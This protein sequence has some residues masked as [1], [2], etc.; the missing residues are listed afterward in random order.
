MSLELPSFLGKAVTEGKKSRP[1]EVGARILPI[2][3]GRGRTWET[4]SGYAYCLPAVARSR[5]EAHFAR[6]AYA[7]APP[8]LQA[9]GTLAAHAL[10]TAFLHESAGCCA[11]WEK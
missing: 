8:L 9:C 10:E 3:D 6:N 2:S 11:L 1:R 7:A 4:A 5:R